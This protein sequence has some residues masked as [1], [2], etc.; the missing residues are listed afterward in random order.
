MYRDFADLREQNHSFESIGASRFTL[1]TLMSSGMPEALYGS[2]VSYDLLTTLGVKP[3]FGRTFAAQ[4]DQPGNEH[5]VILS[6]DTWQNKF[7]KDASIIGK[8]VNLIY[9]D[10]QEYQ[11]IGVMPTGFNYP[12]VIPTSVD[13]PTRQ[14]AFWIPIGVD[15]KQQSRSGRSVMVTASLRHGV[16]I[17]QAQSDID[18]I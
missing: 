4:D 8:K 5:V 15:A 2:A 1:M 13:P 17:A 16:S 3:L 10:Q 9:Q 11:V 14:M 6:Y 12:L 7:G 18:R